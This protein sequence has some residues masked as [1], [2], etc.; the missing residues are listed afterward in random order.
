MPLDFFLASQVDRLVAMYSFL[1]VLVGPYLIQPSQ[2]IFFLSS[3]NIFGFMIPNPYDQWSS[4]KNCGAPEAYAR[5]G[6]QCSLMYNYGH[7]LNILLAALVISGLVTILCKSVLKSV[8]KSSKIHDYC[9]LVNRYFG[10]RYFFLFFDAV[11]LELFGLCLLNFKSITSSTGP[12][13]LGFIISVIIVLLYAGM[14]AY[15]YYSIKKL[16][17]YKKKGES[18]KQVDYNCFIMET[19][20]TKTNL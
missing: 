15:A 17:H 1:K 16:K 11:F 4:D 6:L 5:N 14:Y 19:A 10:L 7:N 12:I 20:D 13:L 8:Q 2:A 3:R 18:L 9:S